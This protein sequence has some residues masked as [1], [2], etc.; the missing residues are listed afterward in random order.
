MYGL[1]YCLMVHMTRRCIHVALLIVLLGTLTSAQGPE[2]D[3]AQ[4]G[5]QIGERVPTFSLVDQFGQQHDLESLMGPNGLW[6]EF[7]RSADW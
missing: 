2:P 4:F 1:N 5:P 6:L 3:V 7:N